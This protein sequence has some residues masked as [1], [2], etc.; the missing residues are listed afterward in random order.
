M[1]VGHALAMS[2]GLVALGGLFILI[3]IAALGEFRRFILKGPSPL[4]SPRLFAQL[5]AS[6]GGAYIAILVV[7]AGVLA[8]VIGLFSAGLIVSKAASEIF[9]AWLTRQS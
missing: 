1:T 7:L 9:A 6:T 2:L 8:A 4:F 5:A 3:G